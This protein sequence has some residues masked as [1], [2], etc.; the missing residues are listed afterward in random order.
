ML[1]ASASSVDSDRGK[2]DYIAGSGDDHSA[3]T[4]VGIVG[5]GGS[6]QRNCTLC[7]GAITQEVDGSCPSVHELLKCSR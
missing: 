7:A 5:I 4:T 1:V 6:A 2:T 3:D